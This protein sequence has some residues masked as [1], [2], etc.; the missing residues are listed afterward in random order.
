[1]KGE[2]RKIIK[3]D[4]S[5]TQ[6]KSRKQNKLGNMEIAHNILKN[7]FKRVV[8]NLKFCLTNVKIIKMTSNSQKNS[9]TN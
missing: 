5:E 2:K 9:K 8:G 7:Y 1:M 6:N 3:S 4:K